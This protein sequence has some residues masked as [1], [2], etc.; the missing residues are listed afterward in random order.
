MQIEII[1]KISRFIELSQIFSKTESDIFPDELLR[2][3]N[4]SN[5]VYGYTS[6]INLTLENNKF[7]S[8]TLT[9]IL[10]KDYLE[11]GQKIKDFE[12]YKLLQ[13]ELSKYF[14]ALEEITKTTK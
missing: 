8:T 12:E 3:F 9:Q 13:V 7:I 6:T 11:L 1:K 4:S 14:A 10:D 5:N 2:K